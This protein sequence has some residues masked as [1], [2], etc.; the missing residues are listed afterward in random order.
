MGNIKSV[1]IF[2]LFITKQTI[3]KDDTLK[4]RVFLSKGRDTVE[5]LQAVAYGIISPTNWG[6]GK[7]GKSDGTD[8]RS[9]SGNG[10]KTDGGSRGSLYWQS[11]WV[12]VR[13]T[14]GLIHSLV[15]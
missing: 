10:R 1:M 4:R 5:E 7:K 14:T 3:N 8:G 11:N 12:G 2:P 13:Q 9:G 15:V 6:E